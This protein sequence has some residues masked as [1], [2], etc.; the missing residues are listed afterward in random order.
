MLDLARLRNIQMRPRPKGQL[1]MGRL[2]L[3]PSYSLPGRTKI[4]VEGADRMP[5]S[6][7]ILGMNHTDRYNYW[8]F[9]Y[10]L[11]QNKQRF[12]ATW[13]KGKYYENGFLGKFMEMMN[14]I[15]APSKG[16]VMTRDFLSTVGRAPSKDE[17]AALRELAAGT[18]P[19]P[20]ALPVEIA[21]RGRDML[22]RQFDPQKE[23]YADCIRLL[24]AEMNELFVG[25]NEAAFDAGLDLLIFP[26]GTRSIRLSKGHVGM[27]QAALHFK[28]DIVPVGCNGSDKVYPGG[29]PWAKSGD[30]CYRVGEPMSYAS[31]AEHHLPEGLSAFDPEVLAAHR[32]SMQVLVDKVM[33]RIN[34]LLDPPYQFGDGDASDGVDGSK[35]FV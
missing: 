27:I 5:T 31:F 9:Q 30:I 15:P 21:E 20:D 26:Q 34:D 8:P 18:S 4:A 12:T 11:W 29:S 19:A 14:N 35:R 24:L 10:W 22:G 7:V 13:V 28:R 6:P 32:D 33:E 16:Y 17:Y 23:S 1:F 25:I 3:G 2:F